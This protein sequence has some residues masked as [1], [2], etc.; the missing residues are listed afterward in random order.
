MH[1]PTPEVNV[2]MFARMVERMAPAARQR[3]QALLMVAVPGRHVG[4]HPAEEAGPARHLVA[5][6][7]S[8]RVP[9][10]GG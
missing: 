3:L 7:G 6:Q 8:G 9:E 2:E 5:V 4:V 10:P 1:A